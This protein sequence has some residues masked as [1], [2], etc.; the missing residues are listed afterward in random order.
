MSEQTLATVPV[1]DAERSII[2]QPALS[3][4]PSVHLPP[5][6]RPMATNSHAPPPTAQTIQHP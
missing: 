2:R 4:S 5:P 3:I 1:S 6:D